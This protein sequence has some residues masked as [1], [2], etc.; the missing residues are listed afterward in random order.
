MALYKEIPVTDASS[1]GLNCA[2]RETA[3]AT[4]SVD[5]APREG[6]RAPG[7]AAYLG[8][9]AFVQ[10]VNARHTPSVPVRVVNVT[11]IPRS[12][13]WVTSNHR[14]QQQQQRCFRRA[15]RTERGALGGAELDH[16]E[17]VW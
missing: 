1:R 4:G 11:H 12:V 17:S 5:P 16:S 10:V 13:A 14:L 2:V 6:K 7:E 3:S 8:V 9:P 15:G